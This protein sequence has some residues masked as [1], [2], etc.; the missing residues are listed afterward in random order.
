MSIPPV[1]DIH[2]HDD[3]HDLGLASD[4]QTLSRRRLLGILGL[5]GLAVAA[6]PA[7]AAARALVPSETAGPY[8][9]DGSNGVDVLDDTGIVRRDIR[10]SFG[11]ASGVA[12]GV[13]LLVNLVLVDTAGKPLSGRAVYLWQAD[14]LGR[15]SMYSTAIRK[16]NYLRGV[17]ASNANGR[18]QF[19]TIYPGCYSGRWPHIH[20]EVYRSVAAATN[21]GPIVRTSQLA[22]PKAMSQKV[23][24]RS[25]YTG[26]AANLAR[27]S[28]ASDNVFGNDSAARQM[29]TVTGTIATRLVATLTIAVPK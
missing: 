19:L 7:A 1:P 23:Y 26:S 15:Y 10:R 29:A 8:P 4:L 13:P 20:F 28:L 21:D 12:A 9:A 18:V 3:D 25:A 16:Q 22:L 17:Q 5:G 11:T 27:I 6:A 24:A 14:A 2:D